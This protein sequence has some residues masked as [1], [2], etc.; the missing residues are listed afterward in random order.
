MQCVT[1]IALI[2]HVTT[3]LQIAAP[4]NMTFF[5]AFSQVLF[6][7]NA[8]VADGSPAVLCRDAT[9]AVA[10]SR[11]GTQSFGVFCLLPSG[12]EFYGLIH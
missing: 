11:S 5:R 4:A 1:M 8:T 10:D 6:K 12:T 9:S 3:C 2:S 7:Y